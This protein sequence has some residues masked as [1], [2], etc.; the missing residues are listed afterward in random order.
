MSSNIF[1]SK[2]TLYVAKVLWGGNVEFSIKDQL[3]IKYFSNT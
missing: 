2:L 3:L 1:L